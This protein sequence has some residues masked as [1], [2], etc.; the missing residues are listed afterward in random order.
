MPVVSS[1]EQIANDTDLDGRRA[2][3]LPP[4]SIPLESEPRA[5]ASVPIQC[6][7]GTVYTKAEYGC[8]QYVGMQDDFA[9]GWLVLRNCVCGSTISV[10]FRMREPRLPRP[11]KVP[12]FAL[13]TVAPPAKESA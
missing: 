12:S 8:L 11:P 7:C 3:T 13:E 9:G 2:S 4:E 5:I 1:A 10:R 6:S